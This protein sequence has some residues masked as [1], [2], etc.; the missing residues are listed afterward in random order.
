[1]IETGSFDNVSDDIE[2]ILKQIFE[3]SYDDLHTFGNFS[4]DP[5]VKEK[6]EEIFNKVKHYY[7]SC[8]DEI[9]IDSRGSKPIH[10][11]LE[12]FNS[13]W[14]DSKSNNLEAITSAMSFLILNSAYPFFSFYGDADAE[15]PEVNTLTLS[16]SGLRLP[17]KQYYTVPSTLELYKGTIKD[18]WSAIFTQEDSKF[19]GADHNMSTAV[20]SLIKFETALANISNTS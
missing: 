12:K 4:I 10:S 18:I 16:Q 15:N 2:N 20:D 6:D 5:D 9:A 1:L 19:F 7:D 13:I 8:N 17:S 14:E 3:H 11:L